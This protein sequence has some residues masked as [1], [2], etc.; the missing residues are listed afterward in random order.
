MSN[1]FGRAA[2]AASEYARRFGCEHGFRDS[3][4]QMGFAE[5][6]IRQVQAWSRM[7]ALVAISLLIVVQLAMKLLVHSQPQGFMLMRQVASRRRGRWDVS[8][9]SA[10]LHLLRLHSDL[11][12]HLNRGLIKLFSMD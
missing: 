11:F 12:D 10:M 7:F 6:H 5:A 3:K 1:R 2:Q 4:W 9:V 8:L